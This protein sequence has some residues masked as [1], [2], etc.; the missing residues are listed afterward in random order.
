ME[1]NILIMVIEIMNMKQTEIISAVFALVISICYPVCMNAATI[2]NPVFVYADESP[3]EV[4][5]I[6]YTK[7]MT[8]VYFTVCP[9]DSSQFGIVRGMF[10]VGDDGIRRQAIDYMGIEVDSIY[11]IESG[12]YMKFTIDFEPIPEN[13]MCLDVRMPS[14]FGIYGLHDTK[15]KLDIPDIEGYYDQLEEQP[16]LFT[17]DQIEIEGTVHDPYGLL[18]KRVYANRMP[19]IIKTGVYDDLYADITP[20]GH[21]SMKFNMDVPQ[22]LNFRQ[23][24]IAGKVISES[25]VARPGD[26]LK[27]DIYDWHE[28]KPL[29]IE[30]ITGRNTYSHLI[31]APGVHFNFAAYVVNTMEDFNRFTYE[32]T[33]SDMGEGYKRAIDF[34]KYVCWHYC[35]SPYEAKLYTDYVTV[36]FI[37][38]MMGIDVSVKSQYLKATDETKKERYRSMIDKA[39]YKYLCLL[40]PDAPQY[41][42]SCSYA[43][44]L[45]NYI[46]QLKPFFD[47]YDNVPV[48]TDDRWLCIIQMQQEL[49]NK[50]TGWSGS[51]FIM[52]QIIVAGVNY[53]LTDRSITAEQAGEVRKLLRYPYNLKRFDIKCSEYIK[54]K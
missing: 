54:K 23:N 18:G 9:D 36:Q 41:V 50:I 11:Y 48:G 38:Y 17:T 15:V 37:Y 4:V 45:G 10:V 26:K 53:V 12:K 51:S 2:T 19:I 7:D 27:V 31:G 8:R 6:D 44:E 13:N 1:Q 25:F 39:D 30:N 35:M 29:K 20:D 42:L 43:E 16:D 32:Q 33:M 52:E 40:S 21:F 24:R 5:R 3:V 49:L 22:V 47:C 46:M 28:G 34:A 14:K